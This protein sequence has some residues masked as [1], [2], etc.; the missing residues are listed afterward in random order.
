MSISALQRCTT[1]L[2]SRFS[3]SFQKPN[4]CVNSLEINLQQPW[5][6]FSSK[7]F[8]YWLL[9]VS[10][11]NDDTKQRANWVALPWYRCDA[12]TTSANNTLFNSNWEMNKWFFNFAKW[13]KIV[14]LPEY[15]PSL[16]PGRFCQ[17]IIEK[18][19]SNL[20]YLLFQAQWLK[21]T[22]IV[23]FSQNFSDLVK[24]ITWV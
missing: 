5:M 21:F 9:L 18:I 14:G 1:T 3:A 7:E 8:N 11:G 22:Q 15:K 13:W 23:S 6:R 12:R 20:D 17:K 19:V 10:L 24:Q 2:F 4:H 16:F